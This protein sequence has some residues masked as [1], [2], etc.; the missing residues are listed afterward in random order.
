MEISEK[1]TLSLVHYYL[2]TMTEMLKRAE[3]SDN[4]DL[5]LRIKNIIDQWYLGLD[6]S[7]F[8]SNSKKLSMMSEANFKS[9]KNKKA[10]EILDSKPS[11]EV[12]SNSVNLIDEYLKKEGLK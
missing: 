9:I 3:Q 10:Q 6:Y 8:L 2:G 1:E 11:K 7:A 12:L 5:I 4:L